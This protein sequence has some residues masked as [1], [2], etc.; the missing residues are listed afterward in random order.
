MAFNTLV[1]KLNQ[2]KTSAVESALVPRSDLYNDRTLNLNQR[3]QIGQIFA[4]WAI[5]YPG[6]F[7][8]K[9]STYPKLFSY[10]IKKCV[11][12]II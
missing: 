3:D 11:D 6:Q 10:F 9:I 8:C 7:F 2:V 1:G 12:V 5:V 4:Y